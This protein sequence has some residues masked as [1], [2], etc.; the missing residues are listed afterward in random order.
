MVKYLWVD[1][2]EL[3]RAGNLVTITREGK[4]YLISEYGES[5]NYLES[6]GIHLWVYD[7]KEQAMNEKWDEENG[8]Y[9]LISIMDLGTGGRAPSKMEV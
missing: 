4:P 3:E 8:P 5:F 2:L 6:Q 7:S 1:K 9:K